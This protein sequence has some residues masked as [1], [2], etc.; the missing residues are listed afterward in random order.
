MAQG[1]L[2]LWT[3]SI[4]GFSL[5]SQL[6]SSRGSDN[7]FNESPFP[8]FL[9][10]GISPVGHQSFPLAPASPSEFLH[11]HMICFGQYNRESLASNLQLSPLKAAGQ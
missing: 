2:V 4:E 10:R 9:R 1:L 8:I 5:S 6:H 11:G 7:T 3:D